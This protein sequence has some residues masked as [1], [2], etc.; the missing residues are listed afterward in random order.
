MKKPVSEP[1]TCKAR[2]RM[3]YR[4]ERLSQ[5]SAHKLPRN[6][7]PLHAPKSSSAQAPIDMGDHHF[8]S[9]AP[10]IVPHDRPEYGQ[11]SP[12]AWWTTSERKSMCQKRVGWLRSRIRST[13]QIE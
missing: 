12:N 9:G 5:P 6:D 2:P 13:P 7:N 4:S 3:P 1:M 11:L 10:S 8:S